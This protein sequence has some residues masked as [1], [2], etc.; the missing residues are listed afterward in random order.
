LSLP[1][2]APVARSTDGGKTWTQLQDRFG[3]QSYGLSLN[4][5]GSNFR[6]DFNFASG[7][8]VDT[9]D[10]P[11]MAVDQSTGIV[12]FSSAN[13][14]NRERFLIISTDRGHSWRSIY[15]IH[16]PAY[17]GSGPAWNVTAADGLVATAYTASPDPE[18]VLQPASFLIPA[19][20]SGRPGIATSSP[21]TTP[22]PAPIR[23]WWPLILSRWVTRIPITAFSG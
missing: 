14:L 17:P 4:F 13:F 9:W 12:Y 22:R 19:P 10:R 1:G 3:S 23:L 7:H 2:D 5:G 11:F 6:S 15:P 21:S 8:P 16:S 18:T 20:I